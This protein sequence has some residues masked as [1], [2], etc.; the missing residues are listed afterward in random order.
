MGISWPDSEESSEVSFPGEWELCEHGLTP[1]KRVAFEGVNTGRRF[2]TCPYEDERMCDWMCW[3]DDEHNEVL[4]NALDR[5]WWLLEDEKRKSSDQLAEKD[6]ALG[7][8]YMA[9]KD[10]MELEKE[11]AELKLKMKQSGGEAGTSGEMKKL[12]SEVEVK[13][14]IY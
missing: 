3:V 13:V 4:K 6:W 9:E 14:K 7:A 2:L 8:R 5:L 10:K 12:G 11:L 1:F